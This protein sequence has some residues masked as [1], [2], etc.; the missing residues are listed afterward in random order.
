ML[1]GLLLIFPH[2]PWTTHTHPMESIK[3]NQQRKCLHYGNSGGDGAWFLDFIRPQGNLRTINC[4][5]RVKGKKFASIC[6]FPLIPALD[7]YA[8]MV[9]QPAI[10]PAIVLRCSEYL[11][12]LPPTSYSWSGCDCEALSLAS[13][14]FECSRW[15]A[16]LSMGLQ[17]QHLANKRWLG[18]VKYVHF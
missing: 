15:F 16:K 17:V 7:F 18:R 6:G 14:V 5:G 11:R 12:K 9:G 1:P 2:S 8:F 10:L 4:A 13:F 3:S